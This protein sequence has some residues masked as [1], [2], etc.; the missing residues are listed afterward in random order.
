MFNFLLLLHRKVTSQLEQD[1]QDTTNLLGT[2]ALALKGEAEGG[3][4]LFG[5]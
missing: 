3:L 5:K 1:Q 2:E 4:D